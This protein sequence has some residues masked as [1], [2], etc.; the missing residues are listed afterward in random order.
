MFVI[1]FYDMAKKKSVLFRKNILRS[2]FIGNNR[3]RSVSLTVLFRESYVKITLPN[4]P[5]VWGENL[6]YNWHTLQNELIFSREHLVND[7][8]IPIM[9]WV[10]VF[11]D[12][13]FTT[14]IS[15]YKKTGQISLHYTWFLETVEWVDQN[16]V[17]ARIFW[18]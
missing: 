6:S 1:T 11:L 4:Q 9:H 2:Q 17:N 7:T 12:V 3:A 5:S 15:T 18:L 10:S 14:V 16:E 8:S 13:N